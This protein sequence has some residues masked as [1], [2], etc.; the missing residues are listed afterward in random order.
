METD[1]ECK[2]P[3]HSTIRYMMQVAC[4]N[5]VTNDYMNSDCVYWWI[6]CFLINDMVMWFPVVSRSS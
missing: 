2:S 1:A 5:R 6:M 3:L 4:L